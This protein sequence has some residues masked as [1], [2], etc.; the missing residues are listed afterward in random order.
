LRRSSTSKPITAPPGS[1]GLLESRTAVPAH[2]IA[3][4]KPAF[5]KELSDLFV[6]R[7][8]RG[9]MI[10]PSRVGGGLSSAKVNESATS[11]PG[12]GG[13]DTICGRCGVDMSDW[14]VRRESNVHGEDDHGGHGHRICESCKAAETMPRTMPG[15]WD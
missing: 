1:C 5:L 13:L 6:P 4:G 11:T 2:D 3:P 15:G 14:W 7:A 8:K 9:K 12:R 10:L